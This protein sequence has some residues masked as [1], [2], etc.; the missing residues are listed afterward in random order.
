MMSATLSF[1]P[2]SLETTNISTEPAVLISA[3]APE[4]AQVQETTST[5]E[6]ELNQDAPSIVPSNAS[7]PQY[8]LS[9]SLT[10]VVD[11]YNEWFIGIPPKPSV[12][13]LDQAY[14]T[15]WRYKGSKGDPD[16][17]K[18]AQ[19]QR[20]AYSRRKKIIDGITKYAS[21]QGIEIIEAARLLEQ[22]RLD[23]DNGNGKRTRISL[24]TLADKLSFSVNDENDE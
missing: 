24:S 16:D 19:A 14:G 21:E 6:L 3:Q 11:V 9:S 20:K 4:S 23:W 13:S 1:P 5:Q 10:T 12:A 18:L 22:H 2:V 7:V 8:L 17:K 15:K